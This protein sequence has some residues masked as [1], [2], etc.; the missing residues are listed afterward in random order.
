MLYIVDIYEGEFD[1]RDTDPS[2]PVIRFSASW[3]ARWRGSASSDE[4]AAAQ[5]WIETIG[6]QRIEKLRELN[7]PETVIDYH[8]TLAL[9]TADMRPSAGADLELYNG[10]QAWYFKVNA[11]AADR[12]PGKEAVVSPFPRGE[13]KA[14]PT[15]DYL[16]KPS[17]N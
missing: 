6:R 1:H 7:A 2:P 3:I 15:F 13:Q 10:C 9:V 4:K 12:V 5:A 17:V 8:D 11:A 16:F 14:E